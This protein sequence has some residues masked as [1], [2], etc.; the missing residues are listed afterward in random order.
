MF[1]KRSRTSIT[2][3]QHSSTPAHLTH[4]GVSQLEGEKNVRVPGE[5]P[6]DHRYRNLEFET[7]VRT[8]LDT[9]SFSLRYEGASWGGGFR[10]SYHL[11]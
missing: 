3:E 9:S 5:T 11:Q 10:K 1:M 2:A 8:C 6:T 7:F 4:V